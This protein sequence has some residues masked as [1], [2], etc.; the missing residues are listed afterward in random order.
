MAW[1]WQQASC[2]ASGA[3][4][5]QEFSLDVDLE[6]DASGLMIGL[7]SCLSVQIWWLAGGAMPERNKFEGLNSILWQDNDWVDNG[8]WNNVVV[9]LFHRS[10]ESHGINANLATQVSGQ[11]PDIPSYVACHI[12]S[13]LPDW[14]FSV[15]RSQLLGKSQKVQQ[16]GASAWRFAKTMIMTQ[17]I[18]SVYC[19]EYFTPFSRSKHTSTKQDG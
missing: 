8:H 10:P 5:F 2:P 18:S 11:H 19:M 9:K 14:G 15:L 6:G 16:P 4:T 3:I 1:V 13:R 17:S 7:E 12:M